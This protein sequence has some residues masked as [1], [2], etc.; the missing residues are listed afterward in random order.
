MSSLFLIPKVPKE[1]C[2]ANFLRADGIPDPRAR[3]TL[4]CDPT[5]LLISCPYLHITIPDEGVPVGDHAP[6]GDANG[7]N[8]LLWIPADGVISHHL[9]D[10][11][12]QPI[13]GASSENPRTCQQE[14]RTEARNKFLILYSIPK[15]APPVSTRTQRRQP[16]F[17][18]CS[19]YDMDL[20]ERRGCPSV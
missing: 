20:G 11:L 15:E 13:V 18:L 3:V 7:H 14:R 4:C 2:K 12:H 5:D 8:V 9:P 1:T 16:H 10:E 19:T 17:G 6:S